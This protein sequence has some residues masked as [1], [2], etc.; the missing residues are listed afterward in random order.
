MNAFPLCLRPGLPI[1]AE[2]IQ[3]VRE[4]WHMLLEKGAKN[5]YPSHGKSFPA[6]IIQ[7]VLSK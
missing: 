5:I 7:R 3:K 6:E 2:D 4:S 1:F